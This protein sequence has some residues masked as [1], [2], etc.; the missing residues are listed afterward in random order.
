MIDNEEGGIL[1]MARTSTLPLESSSKRGHQIK[2][3]IF[4]LALFMQCFWCSVKQSAVQTQNN[5]SSIKFHK[6]R[7]EHQKM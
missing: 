3:A 5:Y 6:L 1:R 2:K 7:K 4:T